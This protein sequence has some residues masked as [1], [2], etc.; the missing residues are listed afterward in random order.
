VRY[1]V[2]IKNCIMYLVLH[3][4]LDLLVHDMMVLQ[5]IVGCAVEAGK[6]G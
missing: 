6:N 3:V 5:K 1:P 2:R 4:L